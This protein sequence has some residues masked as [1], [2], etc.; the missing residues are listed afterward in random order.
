MIA[1]ATPSRA[2]A[3][4]LRERLALLGVPLLD[5][6]TDSRLVKHGSVFVAYPGSALDGRAYIADAL[7]RGAAAVIWERRGF[8]WNPR[9][10]A[11]NLAIE[12]LRARA[13]EIAG[14][15]HGDPS[16]KL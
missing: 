10:D 11:P 6:T 9:W 16:E 3:V 7:A 12:D 13:S 15:V 14:L 4:V 1:V 8:D 5:L 2:P